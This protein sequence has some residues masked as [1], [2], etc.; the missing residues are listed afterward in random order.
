[1]MFDREAVARAERGCGSSAGVRIPGIQIPD[2]LCNSPA[3]LPSRHPIERC[4]LVLVRSSNERRP[5]GVSTAADLWTVLASIFASRE[6]PQSSLFA[7]P[8]LIVERQHALGPVQGSTEITLSV[9]AIL[10]EALHGPRH[11]ACRQQLP[12]RDR[13]FPLTGSRVEACQ[14]ELCIIDQRFAMV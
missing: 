13:R 7:R 6:Q 1:M 3:Q 14:F 9:F 4:G 10:R 2:S 5:P 8:H 12:D 11:T